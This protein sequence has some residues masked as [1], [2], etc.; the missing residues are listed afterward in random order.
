MAEIQ[1]NLNFVEYAS[2]QVL[3]EELLEED[4]PELF[5]KLMASTLEKKNE[6]ENLP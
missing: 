6:S 4:D 2:A 1:L 3:E 5:K